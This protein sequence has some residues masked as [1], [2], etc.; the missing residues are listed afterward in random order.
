MNGR[1]SWCE[2]CG[3]PGHGKNRCPLRK[4]QEMKDPYGNKVR[5]G[6][7]TE[8]ADPALREATVRTMFLSGANS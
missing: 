7:S 5:P 4:L 1:F 6:S 8:T 3:A 2:I